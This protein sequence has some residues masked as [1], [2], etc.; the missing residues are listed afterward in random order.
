MEDEPDLDLLETFEGWRG[1]GAPK[2][3]AAVQAALARGDLRLAQALLE[4]GYPM[5]WTTVLDRVAEGGQVNVAK[6]LYSQMEADAAKR[7]L[8]PVEEELTYKLLSRS[9]TAAVLK[10]SLAYCDWVLSLIRSG[11]SSSI[12]P[13]ACLAAD[14]LLY[15]AVQSG[16]LG[17]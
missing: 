5:G 6:W 9:L 11:T 16:S 15:C 7:G 14:D 10:N 12:L 3:R 8:L 13:S 1:P 4:C 17:E 2:S